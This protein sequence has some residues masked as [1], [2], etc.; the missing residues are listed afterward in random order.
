MIR[1]TNAAQIHLQAAQQLLV[2]VGESVKRSGGSEAEEILANDLRAMYISAAGYHSTEPTFRPTQDNSATSVL[3]SVKALHSPQGLRSVKEVLFVYERLFERMRSNDPLARPNAEQLKAFTSLWE[4]AILQLSHDCPEPRV[5]LFAAHMLV[6]VA[7]ALVPRLSFSGL[8]EEQ[9]ALHFPANATAMGYILRKLQLLLEED[10]K[11]LDKADLVIF[12]RMLRVASNA[13][14]RF[15]LKKSQ[16]NEAQIILMKIDITEGVA[17]RTKSAGSEPG[18]SSTFADPAI[19]LPDPRV[20][21]QQGLVLS[22]FAARKLSIIEP[23]S[24][25]DASDLP[26]RDMT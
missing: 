18:P 21:Q 2:K 16:R 25:P 20:Q 8:T 24:V 1:N 13:I 17:V 9:F 22:E 5:N 26:L 4:L 12:N 7:N 3:N 19:S 23:L 6:C 14:H 15:A 11:Q 10:N